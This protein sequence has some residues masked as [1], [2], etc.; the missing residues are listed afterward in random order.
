MNGTNSMFWN[1]NL[2]Q[3]DEGEQSSREVSFYAHAGVDNRT[4]TTEEVERKP[5]KGL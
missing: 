4:M 1:T 2:K 3:K 5:R